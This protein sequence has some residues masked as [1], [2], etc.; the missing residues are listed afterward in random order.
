MRQYHPI[1]PLLQMAITISGMT[2][3]VHRNAQFPT[4]SLADKMTVSL[5]STDSYAFNE[6]VAG[7]A[8]GYV[9]SAEA[10]QGF[11][12][13]SYLARAARGSPAG[14]GYS[15]VHDL[16]RFGV[17]ILEGEYLSEDAIAQ[18]WLDGSGFNTGFYGYGFGFVIQHGVLGRSV[19]HTGSAP[20]LSASLEILPEEGFII[21]VLSNYHSVAFPIAR[22][23]YDLVSRTQR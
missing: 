19:G 16:H 12:K 11:L 9:F 1:H 6:V 10:E 7:A 20:G 22:R 4:A 17:S 8:Q 15:T 2:G 21:V 3:H 23:L 14:G 5:V 18:M 13:A